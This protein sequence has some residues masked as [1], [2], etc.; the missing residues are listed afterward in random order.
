M[1]S[2][3]CSGKRDGGHLACNYWF[4]PPN[5]LDSSRRGFRAPYTSD[6][7]PALWRARVAECLLG[8][9]E[10]GL[11]AQPP[12]GAGVAAAAVHQEE[13]PGKKRRGRAAAG[14]KATLNGNMG[15]GDNVSRKEADDTARVTTAPPPNA[16]PSCHRHDNKRVRLLQADEDDG[17]RNADGQVD[18]KFLGNRKR[19]ELP[20]RDSLTRVSDGDDDLDPPCRVAPAGIAAA[21]KALDARLRAAELGGEDG[22]GA[23][24]T[25]EVIAGGRACDQTENIYGV[26]FL[27]VRMSARVCYVCARAL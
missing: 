14:Q 22:S 19:R 24:L 8:G 16:L 15:G 20:T 1:T 13:L 10:P 18:G 5:N 23:T 2:Y 12:P 7:W 9:L 27:H 4:H 11:G 21:V 17:G 3:G 25:D 26:C 6:F